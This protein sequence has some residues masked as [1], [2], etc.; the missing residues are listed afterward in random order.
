MASGT[1]VHWP[2]TLAAR[3]TAPLDP[4]HLRF[5]RTDPRGG[6][7]H[8][9]VLDCSGS[10][11][12]GEPLALAKGVLLRLLERAY[13][14]RAE[15]A[16]VC[17]AAGHAEVRLAPS[18]A[19]R[20]NDDWVRP[21]TGG[22]G[23]PLALGLARADQLLARQAR[24]R[25]GQQRWLWLLTD[26]RS[27]ESPPRPAWADHV[28]VVDVERNPVPLGRCRHLAD[29]WGTEYRSAEAAI[30]DPRLP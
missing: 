27:T 26:G 13:Q 14:T 8:C 19:R 28:V 21:I 7:L 3:G 20:W 10:M 18:R 29:G 23:T 2:R 11:A 17:F 5:R 12:H 24:Q 25:P 30:A 15:V 6:V 9:V 22:G 16:L 4:S 1:C